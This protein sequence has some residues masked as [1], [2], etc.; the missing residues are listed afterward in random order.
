[1][2]RVL[3]IED[4][5]VLSTALETAFQNDGHETRLID[6]PAALEPAMRGSRTDVLVFNLRATSFD[7]VRLARVVHQAATPSPMTLVHANATF[8]LG[9]FYQH[10]IRPF[11]VVPRGA[12]DRDLL[13]AVERC[14]EVHENDSHSEV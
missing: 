9:T 13:D 11:E 6:A 10:C 5:E 2:A 7:P 14:L 1:M 8:G 12:S 3:I 4:N